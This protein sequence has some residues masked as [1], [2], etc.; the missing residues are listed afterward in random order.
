MAN[1]LTG[2]PLIITD[3][4]SSAEIDFWDG[5]VH[6]V[7]AEWQEPTA[8]D[9]LTIH[10]NSGTVIYDD[11]AI[12]GGTGIRLEVKIG[13]VTYNGFNVTVIDGGTLYVYIR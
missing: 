2:N 12:A 4:F 1:D 7:R 9:D 3:A 11:N 6:V 10:D 8:A 13:G 5:P